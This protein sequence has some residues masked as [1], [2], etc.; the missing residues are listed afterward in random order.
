MNVLGSLCSSITFNRY[1]AIAKLDPTI[2]SLVPPTQSQHHPMSVTYPLT[3]N[4]QRYH[5]YHWMCVQTSKANHMPSRPMCALAH[6][7]FAAS[8]ANSFVSAAPQADA[9]VGRGSYSQFI[10]VSQ[11]SHLVSQLPQ[12]AILIIPQEAVD[13]LSTGLEAVSMAM[14][15]R[16]VAPSARAVKASIYG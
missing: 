9:L 13:R 7:Y 16:F 4:Q 8:R 2:M 5:S 12:H 1:P 15:E 14:F 11:L 3:P 10:K 6:V